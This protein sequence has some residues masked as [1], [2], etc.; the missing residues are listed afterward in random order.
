MNK[1]YHFTQQE[2]G[3]A[4]ILFERFRRRWLL[5]A[6][7]SRWLVTKYEDPSG[8]IVKVTVYPSFKK[9]A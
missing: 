9:G 2:A 4:R 1:V 8:Y 6:N 3:V 5:D 7:R